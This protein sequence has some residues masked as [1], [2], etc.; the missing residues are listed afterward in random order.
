M[1]N[2]I[3]YYKKE[4]NEYEAKNILNLLKTLKTKRWNGNE[5][6]FETL[7]GCKVSVFHQKL[8]EMETKYGIID[9]EKQK[10]IMCKLKMSKMALSECLKG[11]NEC[12]KKTKQRH[13]IAQSDDFKDITGYDQEYL[14]RISNAIN[15]SNKL[16]KFRNDQ[17]T[18]PT[19]SEHKSDKRTYSQ[20]KP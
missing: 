9:G 11:I 5:E 7:I 18:K 19:K 6:R 20:M 16:K 13:L 1:Q 4:K 2:L 15:D 17:N 8:S 12:I 3:V 10:E 14:Q